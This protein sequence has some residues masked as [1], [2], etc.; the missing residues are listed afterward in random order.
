LTTTRSA[1]ANLS[2]YGIFSK[3]ATGTSNHDVKLYSKFKCYKEVFASVAPL[4]L[5]L[6]QQLLEVTVVPS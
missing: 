6:A 4:I 3:N 2:A 5:L 1:R